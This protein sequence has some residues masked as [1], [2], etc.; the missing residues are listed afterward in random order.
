M[1]MVLVVQEVVKNVVWSYCE[2]LELPL[3]G[4]RWVWR[5]RQSHGG[6][7]MVAV[8]M[9]MVVVVEKLFYEGFWR[10]LLW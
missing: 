5:R 7:P 2:K 8:M 1:I 10:T 9:M 3:S 4:L 6:G